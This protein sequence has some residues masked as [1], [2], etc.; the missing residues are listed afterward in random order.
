LTPAS[1]ARA[2]DNV[3]AIKFGVPRIVDPVHTYGEPDIRVAPNG[4]VYV[5]GPQGTGVQRSIWNASYDNGDSYRLVQDNKTG[6]APPSAVTPTKSTMGPGGG[7]TEIAI[8]RHNNIYYADLYALACFTTGY[9]HD[10]GQTVQSTPLGCSSAGADRQWFAMFDPAK[11]DHTISPY[12]GP[13]PIVYMKYTSGTTGSKIDYTTGDDPTNWHQGDGA[14]VIADQSPYSPTDAPMV[15]DQHTGD[16]LNVVSVGNNGLALAVSKPAKDGSAHLATHYEPIVSALPGNPSTLFPGFAEDKARNL[17]VVWVDDKDYQVYY[18]YARPKASGTDWGKWSKP[19]HI[20]RPPSATTLMPWVAAGKGGIIDVVWYG[21]DMSLSE[22]GSQGPSAQKN[23]AWYAWFAQINHAAST[24]HH[25]VQ[26][27]ASQHPMHYNDICML[28]TGCIAAQGNRN[29]ADFFEVTID[30]QGRARI[31]FGDT[32]NNLAGPSGAVEAADH[33]GASIVTVST[34]QT[35]LNAW[36][37]KSLTAKESQA[38]RTSI[39]DPIGDAR[40]PVLGGTKV[41]GADIESVAMSQDS[42]NLNITVKLRHGTL[43]DAAT[44]AASSFGRLVVRWQMHNTLYHAGVDQSAAG[45]A[46]TF[47]AGKTQSTDSCSVSACDPHTLDYVAPPVQGGVA[48]TGSV[49]VGQNTTYTIHV[50]LSAIGSPSKHRLLEEVEAYVLAS[51]F[52]GSEPDTKAQ[53]DA[54]EL[55]LQLEGTK[56]FNFRGD[57]K[58]SSTT[59]GM[60]VPGIAVLPL[61]AGVAAYRRRRR[62]KLAA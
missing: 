58:P 37:G 23:E 32:S 6:T 34:Q 44:A 26:S 12:K 40:Y 46:P 3:H 54:D 9:S 39:T 14:T 41:A 25:I 56:S 29:L 11:S 36:T 61:L 30:N 1:G 60:L 2:V 8:D 51:A 52:P 10:N 45:G 55:P 47:Y 42:K 27:R 19:I 33:S 17:Y 15:V 24:T 53:S 4:T 59:A 62:T 48:A 50:P 49:K 7:D 5:S 43:A 57:A 16:G 20:N 22:L 38:P 13:K 35:G 28:G 18:S 21:T 31:V